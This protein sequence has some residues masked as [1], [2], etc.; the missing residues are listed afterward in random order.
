MLERLS[1][2]FGIGIDKFYHFGACFISSLFVGL[3][4][5]PLSGFV[6]AM[7]LGIGKE[8]GDSKAKGNEWSWGDIIA[9]IVGA[10]VGAIIVLIVLSFI[11]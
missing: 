11:K 8:Y 1:K 9:D 5:G 6:S 10:F 4:L 7:A 2:R 3:V